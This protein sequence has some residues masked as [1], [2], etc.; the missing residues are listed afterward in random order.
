MLLEALNAI[1]KGPGSENNTKLFQIQFS[2]FV[3]EQWIQ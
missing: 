3:T 1:K 2:F